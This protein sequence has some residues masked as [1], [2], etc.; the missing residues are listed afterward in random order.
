LDKLKTCTLG[1]IVF[2]ILTIAGNAMADTIDSPRKQ[3]SKGVAPQ[4]VICQQNL[5][6]AILSNNVPVCVKQSTISILEQRG[7]NFTLIKEQTQTKPHVNSTETKLPI[8][9]Q[10]ETQ[11]RSSTSSTISGQTGKTNVQIETIPASS[12]SIVNF[13]ITDDDLNTSR[14]GVDIIQT[15][16]LVEFYINGVQIDGPDT[17]IET[18]P[19]TGTFYLRLELPSMVNGLPIT[20]N[21][22][23]EVRYLDES[24]SS[25]QQRQSVKSIPLSQTYAQVQTSGGGQSRIGHEFIVRIY[26]P[27]ANL[28][29]KNVDRI[30]LSSVEY[31]GQG[32]IRTTLSNPSF[33]AN[34][35][36]L[37]ETGPNTGIFEV[38][39]KIPRSLDGKTIHIGHWYEIVYTDATTPSNTNER[40]VLQGRIG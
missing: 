17:M 10:Q 15:Q 9:P 19:N 33:D 4:D 13:Y 7:Y 34:A 26:E 32:G 28:D 25:G 8:T 29:S 36:A 24:D 40:V 35:S 1:V 23:I 21:D 27:D 11:A 14:N 37:L 20:Q 16:G 18:G 31:R 39:I 38:V 12:R 30:P 3:L 5:L 6:L 22:I 2:F